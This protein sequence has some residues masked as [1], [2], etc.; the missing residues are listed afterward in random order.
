[1]EVSQAADASAAFLYGGSPMNDLPTDTIAAVATPRGTGGI[2]I[3]KISG[4]DALP[5]L[6]RIFR[7]VAGPPAACLDLAHQQ[8]HYGHIVHPR[9]GV[10]D[11]VLVSVMRG[12]HSYTTQDVVE[13]NC[14]GGDVVTRFVMALVLAEG[15]RPAAPGEF[16]RRAFL[17]G[18]INLIQAEAVIDLINAKTRK[19]AR[20]GLQQLSHG[21]DKKVTQMHRV[22]LD[23]LAEIEAYIDFDDDLEE[24]IPLAP[25]GKRF[26][27]QILPPLEGLI[28]SYQ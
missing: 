25:L 12:P 26:N 28:E 11:E 3:I 16:T 9:E 15:A 21:V 27:E 17:G 6:R 20:A 1:M 13:I 10:V 24:T 22:L 7:K 14:H 19:A 8:M 5:I 2:A 4:P 23:G 18:R